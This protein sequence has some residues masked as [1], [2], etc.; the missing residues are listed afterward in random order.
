MSENRK[1][2]THD[3]CRLLLCAACGF[4]NT[5]CVKMTANLEEIIKSNVYPGYNKEDTSFPL[6]VCPTCRVSLFIAK[7]KGLTGVSKKIRDT[8]N[9]NLDDFR[10]PS[11]KTPCVCQICVNV[12]T[13]DERFGI[14]TAKEIPRTESE[15]QNEIQGEKSDEEGAHPVKQ[16]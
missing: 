9:L 11:R 5:K 15:P 8:W 14:K 10:A 6:G 1:A 12:R 4:K 2:R 3:E 13:S 7:K 16:I